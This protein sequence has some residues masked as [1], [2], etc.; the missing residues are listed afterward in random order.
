MS[1]WVKLKGSDL[2]VTGYYESGLSSIWEGCIYS[3]RIQAYDWNKRAQVQ[4]LCKA[5]YHVRIWKT[6]DPHGRRGHASLHRYLLS[7]PVIK[8]SKEDDSGNL[9]SYLYCSTQCFCSRPKVRANVEGNETLRK[10]TQC[11]CR[12]RAYG[13]HQKHQCGRKKLCPSANDL[14]ENKFSYISSAQSP[15]MFTVFILAINRAVGLEC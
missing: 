5:G 4:S 3:P 15:G 1:N 13:N 9:V 6:I 7:Q 11:S 12:R 10:D 14:R 2:K 8:S